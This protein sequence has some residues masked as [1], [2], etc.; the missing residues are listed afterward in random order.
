[1]EPS[2]LLDKLQQFCD[3][4]TSRN[5]AS[6][7]PKL[8]K[9]LFKTAVF[10]K[11]HNHHT[12]QVQ[13]IINFYYGSTMSPDVKRG[14][15]ATIL[16]LRLMIK[17]LHEDHVKN[18]PLYNVKL[19]AVGENKK[20]RVDGEIKNVRDPNLF[21]VKYGKRCP[22]DEQKNEEEGGDKNYYMF[23]IEYLFIK[24]DRI[25]RLDDLIDDIIKNIWEHKIVIKKIYLS[26]FFHDFIGKKVIVKRGRKVNKNVKYDKHFPEKGFYKKNI[27]AYWGSRGMYGMYRI[28]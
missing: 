16:A 19:R 4:Q 25:M 11:E 9:F 20:I 15:Q 10:A 22:K 5:F 24:E 7:G 17:M 28:I 27:G 12:K 1:M 14:V 8:Q 18:N 6:L 26:E 23:A 3:N 21:F 2:Y 13:K